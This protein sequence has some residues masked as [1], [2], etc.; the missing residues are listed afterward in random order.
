MAWSPEDSLVI[1]ISSRAL[2]KL[3]EEDRIYREQGTEVFID[4]QRSH[5]TELI[6]PGVAFPLVEALLKLNE[7]LRTHA[8]PAIEVV[9]VSKNHPECEIRIGRSL[10]HYGLKL[11]RAVFTGGQTTLPYLKAFKVDLFLSKEESAVKEAIGIG[12]SAG[13]IHGGPEEPEPLDGTPVFAFDGDGVLFSGEADWVFREKGIEGFEAFEFENLT[14][15][16]PPGPLHKFA[17]ALEELRT[18]RPIDDPP[19]RIALVTARAVTYSARPLNTLREWG[20]RVDQSFFLDGMSKAVLLSALKPLIF[21]DDSVNNCAEACASTPTVRIPT[22]EPV[23]LVITLSSAPPSGIRS[24]DRFLHI[25]KLVLK[26]S[27]DQHEPT[28]RSWREAKLSS[29]TD[30]ALEKFTAELE[31]SAK[32]T[33]AGRQRRAAG[34]QNE[35][36]IKL[37]QFLEN[38]LRKYCF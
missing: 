22:E 17:L 15:A 31:R 29:L 18:G 38:S 30:E 3:D 4:Y 7:K 21:F 24:P 20:I 19:F 28:L 2:F 8:S 13:L 23:K 37:M 12:I 35:D 16:L 10:D 34:A 36:F 14:T 5:E 25:C 9:I 32:G 33:P 11:R 26:K 27:F 1:G 6:K